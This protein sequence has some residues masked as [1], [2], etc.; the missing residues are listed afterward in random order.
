V[1]RFSLILPL[2]SF[3]ISSPRTH[4]TESHEPTALSAVSTIVVVGVG[5]CHSPGVAG[6]GL[7]K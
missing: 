6:A 2:A 3:T 4:V 7:A 1:S 5:P